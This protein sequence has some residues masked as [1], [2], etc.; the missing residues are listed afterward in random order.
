M[1]TNSNAMFRFSARTVGQARLAALAA[2]AAVTIASAAAAGPIEAALVESL[3]GTSRGVESMDYVRSGQVIR[4]GPQQTIVLSYMSSCLRETITGGT[5]MV[6]I[7]RSE[8]QSGEVRRTSG[9]CEVRKI[10]LTSALSHIGGR[11]FRGGA[12]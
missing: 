10:E 2:A 12:Q 6:G 4:L 9:Q 7:D 11:T 1:A 8:V 5:V 3:T